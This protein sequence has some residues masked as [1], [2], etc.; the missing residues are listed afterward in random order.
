MPHKALEKKI[1]RNAEGMA[2]LGGV[3][4]PPFALYAVADYNVPRH[5]DLSGIPALI[6]DFVGQTLRP[7]ERVYVDAAVENGRRIPKYG[8][9]NR[10]PC[11]NGFSPFMTRSFWELVSP[12]Q[13]SRIKAHQ[14][15]PVFLG[16]LLKWGYGAGL[17]WRVGL[18][19]VGT[20]SVFDM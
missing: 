20:F 19:N 14:A 12:Y 5:V 2:L 7:A 8:T 9:I 18:R 17:P 6:T 3:L 10:I 15:C 11:I 13:S 16:C 4:L 1:G